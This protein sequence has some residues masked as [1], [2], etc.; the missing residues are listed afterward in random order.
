MS[1]SRYSVELVLLT[2]LFL[3]MGL[4]CLRE[5]FLNPNA[6]AQIPLA[7]IFLGA[8]G[9]GFIEIAD[10]FMFGTQVDRKEH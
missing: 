9:L 5:A 4:A 2:V 8:A 3:G 6:W 10:Q 1:K 7:A